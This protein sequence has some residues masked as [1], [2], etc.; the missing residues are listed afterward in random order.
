LVH[1][2]RCNILGPLDNRM[3][4]TGMRADCDVRDIAM[5]SRALAGA[6][7]AVLQT[8]DPASHP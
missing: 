3:L 8:C 4:P 6:T 2:E 7:S 5:L 1:P